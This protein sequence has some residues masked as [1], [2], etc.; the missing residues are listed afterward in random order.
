MRTPKLP[1]LAALGVLAAS[2][3][4]AAEK[5]ARLMDAPFEAVW[6]AAVV[7]AGDAFLVSQIAKEEGRLRI[8]AGPLRA[9]AFD[10]TVTP[11][12]REKTRVELELRTRYQNVPAV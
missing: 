2:G 7:V 10:V 6:T 1:A 9:Y 5:K 11:V 4:A 12:G 3:A 8:R